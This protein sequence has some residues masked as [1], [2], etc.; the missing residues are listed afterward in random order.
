M[1]ENTIQRYLGRPDSAW[2]PR[3]VWC[4]SKKEPT[5]DSV[6][7]ADSNP[8]ITGSRRVRSSGPEGPTSTVH[9]LCE[10][11]FSF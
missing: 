5:L 6:I 7:S 4:C 8:R 10:G 3:P 9:R 2:C 11:L 1:F